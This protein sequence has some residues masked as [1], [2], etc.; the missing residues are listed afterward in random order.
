MPRKATGQRAIQWN[1]EPLRHHTI[2]LKKRAKVT[3]S[4]SARDLVVAWASRPCHDGATCA[5]YY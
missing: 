5:T 1:T 4:T 2:H 3:W